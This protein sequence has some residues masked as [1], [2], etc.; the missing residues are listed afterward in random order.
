MLIGAHLS[1]SKG[2]DFAVKD[3]AAKGG[4]CLQ[5]F[6]TSPRSWS[7]KGFTQEQINSFIETK[8]EY[9]VSPVFFHASYL[10]NLA[11]NQETGKKSVR[12][13]INELNLASKMG[14]VGSVVHLGSFKNN[15]KDY[16]LLIANIKQV[17][18]ETNPNTYFII[19]N[20]GNRKIGKDLEEI[21]LILEKLNS[22]R[23]KV[24]L[25]SCHLFSAGIDLTDFDQLSA[26]WQRFND[27]IGKD[28]L[29][30]W[31]LNDSKDP[32][33]SLRDRHENL[34]KGSIGKKGFMNILSINEFRQLPMII[35]TPGF[36]NK[37]PDK[38]NLDILKSLSDQI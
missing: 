19:E 1:I 36:D 4:N 24:C 30:L 20:A 2:L 6:S 21:A 8:L 15:D 37:G 35:E 12:L 38:K 31:H 26:Y 16:D 34:T 23:V 33:G 22:E 14:I 9:S 5:I 27:L 17:L 28:K 18:A 25:D 13:L 29:I 32:L 11:D 10:I 3:I 7:F